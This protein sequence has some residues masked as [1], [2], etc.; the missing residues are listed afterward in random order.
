MAL[1]HLLFL[2]EFLLIAGHVP[3]ML[4]PAN[5]ATCCYR[6]VRSISSSHSMYS[7][8][9]YFIFLH[10]ECIWCGMDLV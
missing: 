5:S 2:H 9:N 6:L 4:L 10:V 7:C 1:I 8:S 3:D